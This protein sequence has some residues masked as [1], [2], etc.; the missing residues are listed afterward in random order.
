MSQIKISV[1]I[2]AHPSRYKSAEKLLKRLNHQ[3]FHGVSLV[4][5]KNNNEWENG[6]ASLLSHPGSDWHIVIQDDAIISKDFYR[7]ARNA[8][9]NVP[10][11]TLISFYTG[12]VRP[13]VTEVKAAVDKAK[14]ARSSWLR[15]NDLYWGVGLAI[16]TSQIDEVLES[17]KNKTSLYDR[18]IGWRYKKHNL[19]VYYTV[20]SLV[21]HNYKIGSILGNDYATEP[22]KAHWYEPELIDVTNWNKKEVKI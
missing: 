7:N 22:R 19:P 20:P 13:K 12:T 1:A 21:D 17:A 10:K 2:M 15:S 4:Y 5:D 14:E 8:I 3:K 18:R 6:K 16:P 9:L 11:P